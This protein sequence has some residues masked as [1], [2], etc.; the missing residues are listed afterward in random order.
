MEP[1][2]GFNFLNLYIDLCIYYSLC[3]FTRSDI[4]RRLLLDFFSPASR[5]LYLIIC[6]PLLQTR[7]ALP[8]FL[9]C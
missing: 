4:L 9:K 1:V 2:I 6:E 7:A 5:S 3:G 8:A